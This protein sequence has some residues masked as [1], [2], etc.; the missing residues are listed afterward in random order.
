MSMRVNNIYLV[1]LSMII[2]FLSCEESI[3]SKDRR[4]A[5]LQ[6]YETL[7]E[8]GYVDSSIRE[9]E[10]YTNIFMDDSKALILLG[11]AYTAKGDYVTAMNVYA[12]ALYYDSSNIQSWTG[13]AK[14]LDQQ[15]LFSKALKVY[16]EALKIDS[17]Y[18]PL[19]SNYSVNSLYRNDFDNTIRYGNRAYAIADK[20][21]DLAIVCFAYHRAGSFEKRDSVFAVLE[22]LSFDTNKL[23]AYM[24]GDK[25]E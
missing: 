15:E 11:Q 16:E 19:L 24:Y 4:E 7:I 17:F 8:K 14:A 25:K 1:F 23:R 9:L 6:E 20:P 22:T 18:Y 10:D 3:T 5:E 13:Y 12:T 21:D 2:G